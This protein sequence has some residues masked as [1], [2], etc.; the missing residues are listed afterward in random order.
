MVNHMVT[1][2]QQLQERIHY[3]NPNFPVAR[4]IDQLDYFA[5]GSFLCHWHT[6]Y[7][8]VLVLQGSVEYQLQQEFYP[9][10]AGEGLLIN[11]QTLHSARRLEPNSVTFNFEFLPSL[12]HTVCISSLYQKYFSPVFLHNLAGY[13]FTEDRSESREVLQS[14]RRIYESDPQAFTYELSCSEEIFRIWRN[15]HLLL[16]NSNYDALDPTNLPE[17]HRIRKMITYIQ[18]HFSDQIA[19]EDIAAAA[20]ISR[21]E[22]FRCFSMFC[23]KPPM[24]YV[25]QYRLQCAAQKLAN[26]AESV[27]DISRY[28]G[29]SSISYF[30]KAFRS[31]YGVSPSDFRKTQ[32]QSQAG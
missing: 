17:E 28:C 25:N 9:L 32:F 29:F 19:V 11:S 24:E 18:A 8:L 22:C 15:L 20:N 6:E 14:I 7:E 10:R 3:E 13:A 4:F 27:T 16:Q 1:V 2:N 12:F 5:E 30:G 26:T 23:H 21:S 31:S